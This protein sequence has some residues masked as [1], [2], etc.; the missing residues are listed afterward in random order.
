M[1]TEERTVA[2]DEPEAD[3][4]EHQ[5]IQMR[6]DAQV[7]E[8]PG[9]LS[10]DDIISQAL[11]GA[12]VY[13]GT[14]ITAPMVVH[15]LSSAGWSIVYSTLDGLPSKINNNMMPAQMMKKIQAGPKKGQPAFSYTQQVQPR[16][17]HFKCMLHPESEQ[18]EEIGVLG[19]DP[20]WS[21]KIISRIEVRNHMKKK[22]QGEWKN[23]QELRGESDRELQRNFQMAAIQ[24]AG[25]QLPQPVM[26]QPVEQPAPLGVPIMDKVCTLCGEVR[27]GKTQEKLD[28]EID[29]HK[30]EK[31]PEQ[32]AKTRTYVASC[33]QC[34]FETEPSKANVGAGS[35][36]RAHKR[37][38]HP[39]TEIVED[40]TDATRA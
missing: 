36:L 24:Q 5:M 40:E 8:E 4:L 29:Q 32:L 11:G 1:T 19:F 18:Q 17:G 15:A 20:C 16:E 27:F 23:I 33:D 3:S 30:A 12:D 38:V 22:H 9:T 7:A 39:P 31:H 26:Q 6:Y 35:S 28:T 14:A 37:N 21:R 13:D 10:R 34:D 2:T 25:G